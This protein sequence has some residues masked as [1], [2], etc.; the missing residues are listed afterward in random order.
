M[1]TKLTPAR[2]NSTQMKDPDMH[3]VLLSIGGH[4][5]SGGAGIQAD[6]ESA[7]AAGVFATT[8][9]TSLTR[10]DTCGISGLWVQAADEVEAQCRLILSDNQVAAVKLGVLGSS[11]IVRVLQQLADEHPELP[12]V[13]D[14]VLSSGAGQAVAD[15][16]VLNQLRKHLLGRCTLV[17]PNLPEARAL[18]G[19]EE[20]EDCARRLLDSGC[21]WVLITGTHAESP[22][23]VNRLFGRDGTRREWSWPR[24]RHRFHGSGCTLASAVAARL[25]LGM[26]MEIAAYEAQAYTWESLNRALRTGRCQL[27]PNRL[28]ALDQIADADP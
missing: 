1:L 8:V 15:A 6:A 10:Q 14:P 24:L 13:L 4:D 20:P 21:A 16:A 22:N 23:V 9:I 5:P 7:R 3:P 26:E 2:Q 28:Y 11:R 27:I 19:A 25:A 18:S 17:T 12:W